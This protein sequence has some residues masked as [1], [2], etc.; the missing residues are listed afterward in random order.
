MK[1]TAKVMTN[2]AVRVD[3]VMTELRMYLKETLKIT[4]I[5]TKKSTAANSDFASCELTVLNSSEVFQFNFRAGLT[6]LP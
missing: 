2:M 1:I 3:M 5:L 6:F 4:G